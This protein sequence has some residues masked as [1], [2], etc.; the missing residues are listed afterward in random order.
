[1]AQHCTQ[2]RSLSDD[3]DRFRDPELTQ[4]AAGCPLLESL[5]LPAE[6]QSPQAWYFPTAGYTAIAENGNLRE[7]AAHWLPPIVLQLC[8]H[9]RKLHMDPTYDSGPRTA[10]P[11][12]AAHCHQLVE[13]VILSYRSWWHDSD[14]EA[15]VLVE[16][17][18]LVEVL[19]LQMYVGTNTIVALGTHCHSLRHLA[20]ST[21]SGALSDE[22]ITT[23]A[24][25]CPQLS[26]LSTLFT[27]PVTMV[28]ITALAAHC[29]SLR[30]VHVDQKILGKTRKYDQR[31][32]GKLK[33]YAGK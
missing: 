19:Q 16:N 20:V 28:G 1:M 2:L 17:C 18:P 22:D 11:E 21:H 8:P 15:K 10:L 31:V 6:V 30:K 24:R 33:L 32:L 4:L 27:L 14:N 29:L 25:G 23:L 3:I 5:K 7:V 26:V 9:L 13:I 12:L